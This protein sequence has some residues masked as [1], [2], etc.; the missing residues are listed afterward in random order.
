MVKKTKKTTKKGNKKSLNQKQKQ[1]I[2]VNIN[3]VKP[4]VRQPVKRVQPKQYPQY[5]TTYP[6]FMPS[7]PS[8]PII[9]NRPDVRVP[10]PE[11]VRKNTIGNEFKSPVKP[12]MTNTIGINTIPQ[13]VI[14]KVKRK[15]QIPVRTLEQKTPIDIEPNSLMPDFL[16]EMDLVILPNK[17]PPKV[18][19]T[20]EE[21][22][23]K[24]IER[25]AKAKATRDAKKLFMNEKTSFK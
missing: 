1:S 3:T 22:E 7:E 23:Q 13:T 19:L 2:V 21:I 12:I 18:V 16:Q 25:N 14:I 11:P 6:V 9:Y 17:R 24:R 4:R 8:L 10:E 5:I 20:A 15:S